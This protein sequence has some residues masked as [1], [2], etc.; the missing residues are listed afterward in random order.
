ML[1]VSKNVVDSQASGHA[2][3]LGCFVWMSHFD[4]A[5]NVDANWMARARNGFTP[6]RFN[7][8]VV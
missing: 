8:F 1:I 6:T 2:H 3:S 5:C 7:M 4:P